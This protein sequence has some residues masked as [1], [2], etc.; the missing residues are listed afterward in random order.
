MG[1]RDLCIKWAIGAGKAKEPLI[2]AGHIVDDG[3]AFFGWGVEQG[4]L[5]KT[6]IFCKYDPLNEKAAKA[7]DEWFEQQTARAF[8]ENYFAMTFGPQDKIGPALSNYHLWWEKIKKA[9]DPN[10]ITPPLTALV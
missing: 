4:H 10:G 8:K 2:K 6:E 7:V 9:I 3:G 5:G 1:Q